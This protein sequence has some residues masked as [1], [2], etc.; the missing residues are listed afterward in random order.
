MKKIKFV[1]I[2]MSLVLM[3]T[4]T[5]YSLLQVMADELKEIDT[6]KIISAG[7]EE[8]MISE[9]VT[10]ESIERES[11]IEK[12]IVEKR[13]ENSKQFLMSDGMVMV[14]TYGMPIHYEENGAF[15]EI[16]NTLKLSESETGEKYFE[17][18]ANSF[19]VRFAENLKTNKGVSVENNGYSLEFTPNARSEEKLQ[20]SKAELQQSITVNQSAV[21]AEKLEHADAVKYSG[22]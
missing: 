16:D 13:T 3:V 20:S 9:P 1:A 7:A 21:T 19:K 6:S 18:T 15:K 12:E 10:E 4:F 8:S 11:Y 22:K 5:P 17:N 14:Q 2:M